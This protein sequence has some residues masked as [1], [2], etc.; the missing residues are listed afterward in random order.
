MSILIEFYKEC[1]RTRWIFVSKVKVSVLPDHNIIFV[2]YP[3]LLH[4]ESIT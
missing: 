4:E 1:K 3:L 2:K